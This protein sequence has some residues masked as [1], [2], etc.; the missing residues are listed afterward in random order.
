MPVYHSL[1]DVSVRLVG[2][3]RFT[4]NPDTEQDKMPMDLVRV[5]MN[6]SEGQ[7]EVDLSPRFFAPFQTI[8]GTAFSNL[9]AR[10]TKE[11]I[12][13]LCIMQSVLRILETDFGR[14]T[15]MSGEAYT[16][17]LEERYAA[18]IKKVT[19]RREDDQRW[20][21]PPLEGLKLAIHNSESDDGYAGM[22]IHSSQSEG[23]DNFPSR[24][25]ND[26]SATLWA[27]SEEELR[28]L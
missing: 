13:N 21:V 26:P 4:E 10:P 18:M 23:E 25:I 1:Q 14:G 9:P 28:S 15:A 2:K 7:V 27:I 17:K 6:E 22:P 12:R 24:R 16:K 3:I 8:A 5:L 11:Y 20:V 19:E